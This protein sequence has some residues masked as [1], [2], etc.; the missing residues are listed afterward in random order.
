M[1]KEIGFIGLGIMGKPMAKN[2]LEAGYKLVCYD[3]KKE[4]V[5]ELVSE[6]AQEGK[7]SKDVAKKTGI[8]IT[9]LPNSPE[10]KEVVLGKEGVRDSAKVGSQAPGH[11]SCDG[12]LP[13]VV[14]GYKDQPVVM[15]RRK[16]IVSLYLRGHSFSSCQNGLYGG[17]GL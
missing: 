9:M 7:S 3:I 15:D 4:A 1:K 8:I 2:L 5:D 17:F 10:V 13:K 11:T 16:A 6:G 12:H 14:F